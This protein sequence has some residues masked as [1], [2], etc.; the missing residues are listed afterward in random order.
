MRLFSGKVT[1]I[2]SE[3]VKSMVD[4]GDIEC[5]AP[6]EVQLDIEAVLKEFLRMEREVSDE[7]KDRLEARSL[8]QTELARTRN[9]IAKE[10]KFPA[11]EDALPYL[12]AQILEMLFHS[13]NVDEVFAEDTDLR[14]K[15]TATLRKHMD[16]EQELDR[17]VRSKIRNMEEGTQAFETEYQKVLEQLKRNKRLT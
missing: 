1:P 11:Q 13:K 2:A 9:Q 4:A 15:T 5:E 12:V 10:R 8:P 3:L 16:V 6:N 14:K 17:E 7:A